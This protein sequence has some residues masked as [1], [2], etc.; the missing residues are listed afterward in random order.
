[1]ATSI[2]LNVGITGMKRIEY[3]ILSLLLRK[4]KEQFLK[5]ET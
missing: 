2:I 5:V 1:M 3:A 4:A